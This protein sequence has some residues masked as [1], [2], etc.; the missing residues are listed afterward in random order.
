MAR[1]RT[2]K[3]PKYV[4]QHGKLQHATS[5]RRFAV[6]LGAGLLV[7]VNPLNSHLARVSESARTLW[8][9]GELILQP[10]TQASPSIAISWAGVEQQ[11]L[12]A[13]GGQVPLSREQRLAFADW[14]LRFGIEEAARM[15]REYLAREREFAMREQYGWL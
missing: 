13:H 12:F 2:K 4:I 11:Y 8:E 14:R 15:E 6:W 7:L 5:A 9:G 3:A 1:K 10:I